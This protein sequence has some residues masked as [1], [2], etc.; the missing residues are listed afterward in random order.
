MKII[1]NRVIWLSFSACLVVASIIFLSIWGLKFGIDFTGGSLLEVK[2]SKSVSV[3]QVKEAVK[4]VKLEDL[5]VQPAE[6][7]VAMLRFKQSTEEIHQETIKKL[8]E[9]DQ[10]ATELR[11]DSI[12]PVIGQELKSKS[13]NA[14]FIVMILIILF[15][16]FAFR[17]VSKP[18][19]SWKYGLAAIVALIHDVMITLGVFV[20]LGKF[21]GTEINTP[22]IAA[23]L[24]VL[25]YSV[26]DTI[27][28]FDRIR[29]NL[30]KSQKNFE[31]TVNDSLNQTIVRSFNTSFSAILALLAIFFFGGPSIKDFALAL[32]V[33]VFIG[34]YSSIFVASP[35]LVIWEK[36]KVKLK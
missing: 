34:T 13:F 10:S 33:G 23:V 7:N 29:E 24:T 31:E 25:G 27:I 26:N 30:P 35:F 1:Q 12:G 36:M 19:A 18:V 15:I 2:F 4:E 16:S 3:D 32:A 17:K 22:F 8:K 20:L 14:V 9:M 28:V 11:F 5:T 6:N 21:L